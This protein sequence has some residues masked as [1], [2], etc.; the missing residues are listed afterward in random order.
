LFCS[1]VTSDFHGSSRWQQSQEQKKCMSPWGM[2]RQQAEAQAVLCHPN[3]TT[4]FPL[5]KA[6]HNCTGLEK[7]KETTKRNW[8]KEKSSKAK[9]A[10]AGRGTGKAPPPPLF[11]PPNSHRIHSPASSAA[12]HSPPLIRAFRSKLPAFPIVWSLQ[13]SRN[14]FLLCA[15]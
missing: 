10:Q 6:Q 12:P 5:T 2:G 9:Q 13:E 8:K 7:R 3:P 1:K 4:P 14:M 15:C 11:S